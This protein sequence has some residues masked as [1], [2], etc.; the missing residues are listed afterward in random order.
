[1]SNFNYL[2]F[3]SKVPKDLQRCLWFLIMAPG[4][5]TAGMNLGRMFIG[6]Q[7]A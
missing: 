5:Y 1:V 2:S 7:R 4:A 3:D 6:K